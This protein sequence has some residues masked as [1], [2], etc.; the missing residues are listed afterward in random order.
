MARKQLVFII[1]KGPS[2][3]TALGVGT[4]TENHSY[5]HFIVISSEISELYSDIGTVFT[6]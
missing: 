1:V 4:I 2:G 6:R 5:S 3:D